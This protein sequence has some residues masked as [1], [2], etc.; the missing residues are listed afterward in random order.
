MQQAH[1]IKAIWHAFKRDE[2]A[3]ATIEFVIVFPVIL[4]LVFSTLEAGWLM[5]EQ[6]ML[7]RG[8]SLAV[9]DV[10]IGAGGPV[11]YA[12]IKDSICKNAMILRNCSSALHL[13]MVE[14][15]NPISSASAACVDR[16]PGAV[17]PLISWIEG[18]RL[19]PEIMVLR[20]CFVVTPLIPGAGFG[21]ALP[22][23]PTGGYHM[24]QYSAFAN[25]PSGG[26]I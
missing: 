25:E 20:A 17:Q 7:G 10:R 5:T 13:E 16:S 22:V 9:R 3:T 15:S 11:T 23:D 21:A 24:V 26:G 2:T 12:S 14:L 4:W 19:T 1:R 6:A 8:L 18:S